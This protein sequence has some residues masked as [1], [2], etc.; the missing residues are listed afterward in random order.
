MR[1]RQGKNCERCGER[2]TF[3]GEGWKLLFLKEDRESVYSRPVVFSLCP[4]CADL[5]RGW[6]TT[7]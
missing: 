3:S 5:L 6:L 7:A 2:R 1:D 4:E